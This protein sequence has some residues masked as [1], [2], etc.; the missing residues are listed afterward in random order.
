MRVIIQTM[1]IKYRTPS[2]FNPLGLNRAQIAHRAGLS[3]PT[4]D[5]V[6]KSNQNAAGQVGL[7]TYLSIIIALRPAD[8]QQ[9]TLGELFEVVDDEAK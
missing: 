3:W 7:G 2:D 1:N 5:Q 6:L 8:W 4:V 9:L